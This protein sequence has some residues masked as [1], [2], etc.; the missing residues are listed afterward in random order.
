MLRHADTPPL[1]AHGAEAVLARAEA[2]PELRAR[3]LLERPQLPQHRAA[4]QREAGAPG[5]LRGLVEG[6]LRGEARDAAV[7]VAL[8]PAGVV[9]PQ[10]LLAGDHARAGHQPHD[11]VAGPGAV[12][13]LRRVLARPEELPGVGGGAA[14]LQRG[15]DAL[16]DLLD[17]PEAQR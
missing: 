14:L 8:A 10:R 17:G 15:G 3:V 4:L 16:G 9:L 7:Q 1:G 12:P 13:A 6:P 5:V 2:I 11:P